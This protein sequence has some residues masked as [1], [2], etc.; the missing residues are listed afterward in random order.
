MDQEWRPIEEFPG[1]SIS[2]QGFVLNRFGKMIA[3]RINNRGIVY[4]GLS[5]DEE[6][7]AISVAR[8]VAVAFL[9][10]PANEAFDTPINLDGDRANNR[11][12][13]LMWRPRWFAIKYSRQF[14]RGWREAND[15]VEEV[16]TQESFERSL[17]A[18][19]RYGLLALEVSTVAW[20]A[21]HHANTWARVWPTGQQ[22]RSL[23]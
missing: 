22:F 18:A 11:A 10:K 14:L 8:L 13:N 16:E 21:T 1:Y 19:M 23:I 6:Q 5:K 9:P 2:N 12:W 20:N 7:F 4:V 3:R 15:P 17:S